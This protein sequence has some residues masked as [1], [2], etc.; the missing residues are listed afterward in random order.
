LPH[1]WGVTLG[2]G[3]MVLAI[4]MGLG[5]VFAAL[6]LIYVGLK[7]GGALYLCYLAWQIATADA[8]DT[9]TDAT[10]RAP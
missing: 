8:G 3:A 2:F 10:G 7:Y 9:Q 4:G 6:P 1:L 5:A